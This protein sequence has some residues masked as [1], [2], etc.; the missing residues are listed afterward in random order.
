MYRRTTVLV[1][2]SLLTM[3]LAACDDPVQPNANGNDVSAP[4]LLVVTGSS[5]VDLGTL[6]GTESRA[7]GINN[8]GL[9]VGS[10]QKLNGQTNAF[11]STGG[12]LVNIH[13]VASWSLSEAKAVNDSGDIAGYAVDGAGNYQLWVYHTRA[14]TGPR[15]G[16]TNRMLS[17]GSGVGSGMNE[18]GGIVG[19]QRIANTW[20]AFRFRIGIGFQTLP[21]LPGGTENFAQAINNSNVV[22]GFSTVAGGAYHAFRWTPAGGMVD[23]GTL[24]GGTNSFAYDVN[25]AG[26]IVGSSE[27]LVN[28]LIETHAFRYRGGVMQ[29]LGTLGR[30]SVAL[31]INDLGE[32]TGYT[33]DALNRWRV[34]VWT[35]DGGMAP[36]TAIPNGGSYFFGEDINNAHQVAGY[37]LVNQ[38]YHA[39]LWQANMQ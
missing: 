13:D 30:M 37:G 26:D 23:L 39:L 5:V 27:M 18:I 29:D 3:G 1:A 22:A 15:V 19:A 2:G 36:L 32:I 8:S 31:G 10:A 34:F 7:F 14:H 17:V 33:L 6:G 38:K 11:R 28:G 35:E 12:A 21:L 4:N 9:L 24:P 16:A 25:Q 20:R